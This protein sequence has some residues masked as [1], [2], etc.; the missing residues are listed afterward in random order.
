MKIKPEDLKSQENLC[1][2]RQDPSYDQEDDFYGSQDEISFS[3]LD[4]DY[5]YDEDDDDI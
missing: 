3:D 1:N 4:F 2:I 5:V